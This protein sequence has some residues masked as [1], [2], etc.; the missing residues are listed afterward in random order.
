MAM[1][2]R[3]GASWTTG[4]TRPFDYADFYPASSKN[5]QLAQHLRLW[6]EESCEAERSTN[7]TAFPMHRIRSW[8]G[9]WWRCARS[10]LAKR[11]T[12][13][14]VSDTMSSWLQLKAL[15]SS[16]RLSDLNMEVWKVNIVV[17]VALRCQIFT[18]LHGFELCI[19]HV[20]THGVELAPLW[21]WVKFKT[22]VSQVGALRKTTGDMNILYLYLYDLIIA[23]WSFMLLTEAK[24]PL[25]L[26]ILPSILCW[27]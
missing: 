15:E 13:F 1:I 22:L 20:G 11:R 3:V 21:V 25:H 14:D 27:P 8:N 26:R 18:P 16:Y 5:W 4:S 10:T 19:F 6:S 9:P 23:I 24:A 17:L 2:C 7:S 12:G